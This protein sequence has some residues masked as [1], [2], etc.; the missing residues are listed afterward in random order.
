MNV[1][2]QF[3][4][5]LVFLNADAQY[6]HGQ[7]QCQG[8]SSDDAVLLEKGYY[9]K[10]LYI[11]YNSTYGKCT[12]YT[13][14]AREVADLINRDLRALNKS[15]QK[16]KRWITYASSTFT[17]TVEPKVRLRLAEV[18]A[19]SEHPATFVCSVYNFYPKNILVTW[20][21]N[22]EEVTSNVT[23]TE[24]LPDGNWLYQRHSHLHYTPKNGDTISCMVEHASLEKPRIYDWEPV[25]ESVRNKIILGTVGLIVGLLSLSVGLIYYKMNVPGRERVSTSDNSRDVQS[26]EGEDA[27]MHLQQEQQE[28]SN[29]SN[30]N[31]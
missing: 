15:L 23:S 20:L 18:V 13:K 17:Q 31:G 28:V 6:I 1:L 21:K 3:C 11:E 4:F 26:G 14:R 25:P 30:N 24:A 27:D 22:G 16:C 19:D 2:L 5:C 9:N 7:T 12:G 10:M 29:N 8:S